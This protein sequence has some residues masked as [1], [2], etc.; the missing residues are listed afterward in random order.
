MFEIQ[1][2][3]NVS[4]Q[5]TTGVLTISPAEGYSV[6]ANDFSLDPSFSD[7]NVTSVAFTQ[8]GNN[9]LCTVTFST[10]FV[11][12][13]SNV[14]INLC[15]IGQGAPVERSIRGFV[16]ASVHE[17]LDAGDGNETLT[18]YDNTGSMNS[19]E[20]L[21]TR[22]YT[23]DTGYYF[24]NQPT[25]SV[26]TGNQSDY[27]IVQTPT[28]NA[29]NQV[30]SYLV[31][32]NYKYPA[33]NVSDDFIK[34]D[35]PKESVGIIYTPQL[36]LIGY[37][38]DTSALGSSEEIRTLTV[39]GEPGTT[40]ST[41]LNDGT[42]NT[43]I[44]DN[45]DIGGNGRYDYDIVFPSAGSSTYTIT[46]STTETNDIDQPNPIIVNRLNDITIEIDV[47]NP[48]TSISGWPTLN[49]TASYGALSSTPFSNDL[50]NSSGAWLIEIDENITPTSGS[51]TFTINKQIQLS[52]F[53]EAT[54]PTAV[55]DGSQ[56]N[57]TTLVLDDT[58]GILAGDKFNY[59]NTDP[60][61]APFTYEVVSVDSATQ[62]TITPSI[63]VPDA[64]PLAFNRS[65]GNVIQILESNVAL[66]PNTSNL[67]TANL[68]F[69]IAVIRYGD[70]NK[71]FNLDLSNIISYTP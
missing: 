14:N 56:T 65:N 18:L 29:D 43:T 41:T 25:V 48:P 24:T 21:F 36:R 33:E 69:N 57:S 68:K 70:A 63:T 54:I 30:V 28:Y 47:T 5:H 8:S 62:L 23:A 42:T 52:D 26:L 34:I 35:I 45:E 4:G 64:T 39:I 67:A 13:S 7:P 1:E 9:V 44:I 50:Y 20:A 59:N 19:T 15:I 38:F 11:M 71:T 32:V 49:P 51:G 60:L 22:T 17:N 40:F 37:E 2:N 10:S 55:T 31:T 66:V 27:N 3:T 53:A 46:I 16:T 6:S 58:T 12:P 61:I